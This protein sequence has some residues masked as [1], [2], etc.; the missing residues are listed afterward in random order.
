MHIAGSKLATEYSERCINAGYVE[1]IHRLMVAYANLP[2]PATA[3]QEI[4]PLI[5]SF[6]VICED[7]DTAKAVVARLAACPG[8]VA[9]FRQHLI[10]AVNC[11]D[12]SP[13]SFV[14]YSTV[15]G[16]AAGILAMLFGREEVGDDDDGVELVPPAVTVSLV[17]VYRIK[18]EGSRIGNVMTDLLALYCLSLSDD[19]T[20]CQ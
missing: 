19:N 2:S 4:V 20:K 10:Y 9:A 17:D 5:A 7:A 6:L 3:Q 18:V 12:A 16:K 14:N 15:P 11:G 13:V 1:F 8:G